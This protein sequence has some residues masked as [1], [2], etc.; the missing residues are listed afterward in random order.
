MEPRLLILSD[1]WGLKRCAWIKHYV[2]MLDPVFS[3][4]VYDSCVLGEVAAA[5]AG[6]EA[7]HSAFIHG[8]I[9]TAAN[10]LLSL[11][12]GKVDILAFSMGGSIAWE[13]GMKGMDIGRLYAVSST[14]LRLQAEKPDCRIQLFY[15]AEDLSQPDLSWFEKSGLDPPLLERGGHDFYKATSSARRIC[16]TIISDRGI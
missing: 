15:G 14:R 4:Q 16:R 1:M 9:D 8:G 13:A 12:T 11:E 10:K 2:E 6:E 5:D 3:V 7:I